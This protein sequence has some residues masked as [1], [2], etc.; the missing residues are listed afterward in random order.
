MTRRDLPAFSRFMAE[1]SESL[2]F[3]ELM[4]W[5]SDSTQQTSVAA[6]YLKLTYALR[7]LKGR[8]QSDFESA[9][10][11]WSECS[12]VM[13]MMK[14]DYGSVCRLMDSCIETIQSPAVNYPSYSASPYSRFGSETIQNTQNT[15][16][17][18]TRGKRKLA[19]STRGSEEEHLQPTANRHASAL[20]PT[21]QACEDQDHAAASAIRHASELPII[22]SIRGH[23][24]SGHLACA[25]TCAD[26]N[27]GAASGLE[28][29][30]FHKRK[31]KVQ[32]V[33]KR[34]AQL[35]DHLLVVASSGQPVNKDKLYQSYRDK[36]N[37]TV[38]D[39]PAE[40]LKRALRNICNGTQ[41]VEYVVLKN[42]DEAP[43]DTFTP[44]D[45]RRRDQP[46]QCLAGAVN[47][48]DGKTLY[49]YKNSRPR[50]Y[51]ASSRTT[52]ICGGE[53]GGGPEERPELTGQHSI[54]D[55]QFGDGGIQDSESGPELTGQHSIAD[56]E[57]R[58]QESV[59]GYFIW[60][61]AV[62]PHA[63]DHVPKEGG[64][65]LYSATSDGSMA[66][67]NL[68]ML[69]DSESDQHSR[70][71]TSVF[72]ILK[73]NC[74]D[75]AKKSSAA[76]ENGPASNRMD[77]SSLTSECDAG[78]GSQAASE[79]ALSGPSGSLV[80]SEILTH[81]EHAAEEVLGGVA[82][83]FSS[84]GDLNMLAETAVHDKENKG[85]ADL[86]ELNAAKVGCDSEAYEEQSEHAADEGGEAETGGGC[87]G[88]VAG[89]RGCDGAGIAE[90]EGSAGG[91][92]EGE[93]SCKDAGR[94]SEKANGDLA[95]SAQQN[96]L[97]PEPVMSGLEIDT[98]AHNAASADCA[99]K[100][101]MCSR[102]DDDIEYRA[103]PKCKKFMCHT[104][105]SITGIL[106]NAVEPFLKGIPRS[107]AWENL[108]CFQCQS[109][110][111]Y[112][113]Y[114][115]ELLEEVGN[116][117]SSSLNT[118]K[119]RAQQCNHLWY[120]V[121]LL[122]AEGLPSSGAVIPP[123]FRQRVEDMLR[124]EATRC[125]KSKR[126]MSIAP[127]DA[128]VLG[129][130]PGLILT[131][132]RSYARKFDF[133]QIG[134][135]KETDENQ[136]KILCVS[137][138]LG[139]HPT[140][141]LAT[142]ELCEMA[143]RPNVWL[144]CVA[145]PDRLTKLDP[146]S[147]LRLELKQEFQERFVEC[148]HLNDKDIAQQIID[149]GPEVIYL[150]GFHQDGD[151]PHVFE[152]VDRCIIVQGLAHASTTGSKRVNYV[153]C[154]QTV[155]PEESKKHFSEKPLY[156]EGTFL[157][158][159]FRKCY[160]CYDTELY[161]FRNDAETRMQERIK[162]GLD[163][164]AQIIV[165]IAKPNRLNVTAEYFEMAFQILEANPG[166]ALVLI[167][168][169][170]PIFR[171]RIEARF[172]KKGLQGRIQFIDF[173]PLE[174]GRLFKF[175]ALTD[176]YLDTLEYN[177]HTAVHDALWANGVVVSV[178]GE[179]LSQRIGADLLFNFG[180][181]ENICHDK[182]AAVAR[183]NTL[184][185]D[186]TILLEA[187]T[188]AENCRL[189]AQMYDVAHRAKMVMEALERAYK[190]M[191][192]NQRK[193]I[194]SSAAAIG[195]ISESD[196]QSLCDLMEGLGIQVN[197]S[198]E[199]QDQF[200]IL[201][202]EFRGVGVVVKIASEP[203]VCP[204][205]N[206]AFCE[207]LA[208]DGKNCESGVQIFPWL[209]PYD[210]KR[211][212][213]GGDL[214]LDVLQLK[215]YGKMLFAVIQEAP[216]HNAAVLFDA[217]AEEWN[218]KPAD[219]T[220]TRTAVL[221]CAMIRL[222]KCLHARGRSY[223]SE[224][225]RFNLSRLRDGYGRRAAAHVEHGGETFSLLLG[226]AER[227]MDPLL[228]FSSPNHVA[229]HA[230]MHVR[231][232][233]SKRSTTVLTNSQTVRASVRAIG[234]NVSTPFSEIKSMLLGSGRAAYNHS[235]IE[236]A[237]RDDLRKAAKAVWNA[238]LGK[239]GQDTVVEEGE[240]TG[241][242]DLFRAWLDRL[243]ENEF[244]NATGV[245]DKCHLVSDAFC[246]GLMKKIPHFKALFELLEH[247]LGD[248]EFDAKGVLDNEPFPGMVYPSNAYPK[249][250][251]SA[252]ENVRDKLQ[253]CPK[254]MQ[255]ISAGVVHMYVRGMT[256]PWKREQIKIIATW[257]VLKWDD[258]KKRCH[259]SL[260]TAEEGNEGEFGAVY[261]ARI[262]TNESLINNLSPIH[263]LR[264]PNCKSVMDGT[265]RASDAVPNAVASC[266]M[267]QFVDS[268]RRENDGRECPD[269]CTRE[270]STD[271]KTFVP[272]SKGLD[273]SMMGL[274][275]KCKVKMYEKL[276]YTYSW[277]KHQQAV[278]VSKPSS[279]QRYTL[280]QPR[281]GRKGL[282][283]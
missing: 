231:R 251:D 139:N 155:L 140:A 222:L 214:E 223:G 273:G 268:S 186:S 134:P 65:D 110:E 255:E 189:T 280:S 240:R 262:E 16:V 64:I 208:R 95:T 8:S 199:Q 191:V 261:Q 106:A 269:N 150:Y 70:E 220:V 75:G 86:Q 9:Q 282:S 239:K 2:Q 215:C 210:E 105:G 257:L 98:C 196:I 81:T 151:R 107:S 51:A 97:N 149:I 171:R 108:H 112:D 236:N 29:A 146:D 185:Q 37:E 145:R 170:F 89:E 60:G 13:R 202:A 62:T 74:L 69:T 247:M 157:S 237:K 125:P 6:K 200:L 46:P 267:G 36:F 135:L 53:G 85:G 77:I 156:I 115:Y 59:N 192:S 30:R 129:L 277:G 212:I 183:V 238:I 27:H 218:A 233:G 117:I 265:P 33:E 17:S 3:P 22:A 154:N 78:K 48:H 141:H 274:K 131:I 221:L 225:R 264:F 71:S 259:R 260:W 193:Q 160:S 127:W 206:A 128:E 205:E 102:T 176:V 28:Q 207:V 96:P 204:N 235:I 209:L 113:R 142:A 184:L 122:I 47:I 24:E 40:A 82:L 11:A 109:H 161:R 241:A 38:T 25:Q 61:N 52:L 99:Q 168:H 124:F 242:C 132:A 4:A 152:G 266:R 201:P 12:D 79:A 58:Y 197:G 133:G 180:T 103:C 158:N 272:P 173:Q 23:D 94:S 136:L 252:P 138:D 148:G 226:G 19:A 34:E 35:L 194:A 263:L 123:M 283:T 190:E 116:A 167:D 178:K 7:A 143:K 276:Y 111:D 121:G 227:V 66:S 211:A 278:D 187:R 281:N 88:S 68:L 49:Y 163:H 254:L 179:R 245:L 248:E 177:G 256:I 87:G 144:M 21:A 57:S 73:Q 232:A 120:H 92:A 114:L 229:S 20:Q 130:P 198:F 244:M 93:G 175:L 90:A 84:Y 230:E 5:F 14:A 253:K 43:A 195:K 243:S 83:Q 54:A 118:A 228:P 56:E 224:P 15:N 217:L 63:F 91:A 67:G 174:D 213:E 10:Q 162:L 42:G 44:T 258:V 126:E 39:L 147:P 159:S 249:G 164:T 270:W 32:A 182:N 275:L 165:N 100:C 153:L 181:P 26:Q 101:S 72:V 31:K 250:L 216:A 50:N 279:L 188:K 1:R 219:E 45:K 166:A 137:A 119:C 172:E 271:W 169:G 41:G 203:D 246:H 104:C 55:E 76:D 234:T 80:C 18:T